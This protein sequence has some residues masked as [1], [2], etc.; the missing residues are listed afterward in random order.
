[1]AEEVDEHLAVSSSQFFMQQSVLGNLINKPAAKLSCALDAYHNALACFLDRSVF[2]EVEQRSLSVL[3]RLPGSV[4][5]VHAAMVTLAA[6]C[7]LMLLEDFKEPVLGYF[8]PYGATWP[9][10]LQRQK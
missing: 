4:T 7:D 8:N 9:A 2:G 6:L 3:A 10:V 1:M 5:E